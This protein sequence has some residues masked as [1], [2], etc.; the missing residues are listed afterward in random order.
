ML[1][2]GNATTALPGF[3]PDASTGIVGTAAGAAGPTSIAVEQPVS[4]TAAVRT[5]RAVQAVRGRA[6]L[7][8]CPMPS[9][10]LHVSSLSMPKITSRPV[11]DLP[12][13]ICLTGSSLPAPA[14]VRSPVFAPSVRK[15]RAPAHQTSVHLKGGVEDLQCSEESSERAVP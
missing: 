1:P 15:D 2:A 14:L 13:A 11:S 7:P 3:G 6:L 8:S 12:E 4:T 9:A 5:A 10:R